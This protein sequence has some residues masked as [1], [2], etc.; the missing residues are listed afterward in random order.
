MSA[1]VSWYLIRT[2]PSKESFVRQRL[3]QFAPEVF[4][5]MLQ[6]PHYSGARSIVPLFPQYIFA[7]LDL[8]AH[9]F[10]IRYMPGVS[11]LVSTGWAPAVVPD[12]IVDSVR[13]RCTD[14]IVI[15]PPKPLRAGEHVRFTEGA[16]RDF[17]AIFERY[18]SGAKRVAILIRTLEGSAMRVIADASKVAP[19]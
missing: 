7:R 1:E 17:E 19:Q 3:L 4:M 2:K 9:Y 12:A 6:L 13:S 14:G 11:G 5:P 8:T 16:F 15:L 10:D 18:L